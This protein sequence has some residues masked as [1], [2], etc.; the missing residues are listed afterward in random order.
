MKQG[1]V[2]DKEYAFCVDS[3]DPSMTEVDV[4]NFIQTKYRQYT[5]LVSAHM[6]MKVS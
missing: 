1:E 6:R 2:E 3:S 5:W 4:F